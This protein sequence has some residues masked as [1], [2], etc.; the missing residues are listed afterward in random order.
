M[1]KIVVR[2]AREHNLKNIDVT[3]PRDKM[4]VVTG[5]SGSG[6]SS[7]VFDT[8]YAEGQRRYVE[9]LSSYARQFLGLMEKPDVDQIDGLSPAISIDQKSTSRNPRS[10]VGTVTEIY[11]YLRLLF[12]RIGVPHCP[13]CGKEITRQTS[14]QIVHQILEMPKGT[15]IMI[16]A[17][18]IK[19]K[20]GEHKYV[21]EELRKAGYTKVR[22][23]GK[24]YD[25]DEELN[26]HK[27]YKH[28][29]EAVADRLIVDPRNRRRFSESV[30]Q[31]LNLGEGVI[32]VLN[33]DS[34]KETT[35]S[36]NYAC[37]DCGINLPELSPRSFSFNSP[38]GA[39]PACTGLGT[40]L[41]VDPGLVVP[42]P[43]LTIAEGAI[44]PW[45]RTT[46]R[47]GWYTQILIAMGQK[48]DFSVNIPYKDLSQKARDLTMYGTG[49]EIIKV[50]LGNGRVYETT[51]EGVIANLGRRYKETDSEYVRKDIEKYMTVKTCQVCNGDRLKPEFASVTVS[52]QTIVDIVN[53]SIDKCLDLF[54]NLKLNERDAE[55][56][57][58][59]L[60]EIRERLQFM[61]NV[62]LNYL[63]LDRTARTLSGGEAQRIRLAT[64]IGSSLMGVL[65]IL[66]EP[67]IGLHQRDNSK[68]IA[69]LKKLRD[70]GNTVI[71][72][73]HD[74]ETMEEADWLLD[75]GPGAGEHGG[76]VI[77]QGTP[78]EVK[79]DK[80]SLTGQYLSGQKTVICPMKRRLGTGESLEI[81]GA[82]ENNLKN[83]DV[84]IP[85]GKMVV[86]TGV[87][88]SG[89]SSLINDTLAKKLANVYHRAQNTPG[90]HQDIL[91]LKN[92]DKVIDI[93]QS[94]I[95]RTPRSNPATYTGVFNNIRE[96]FAAVPE[97]KMRG[98]KSGRFS[99][100]VKGGRCEACHGE[101]IL[102]IEMHFLPDVYVTCE[103]CKGKRYNKEALE[104]YYKGKSIADVLSMTV[105]E[106]LDFFANIPAIRV[107]LQ[108]LMEV[109]L[110]YIR[111]GQPA[112]TLSGGEAQRVKLA[113]ELSRKATGKTLYILDEP[114][115]GLH[116]D[117]VNRLMS[118]LNAL[119]DLGNTVLIVEHN[120]DVIKCADHIIDLGPE[121]GD[122]G[123]EVVAQGTPEEVAKSEISYTGQ[124]LRK[125]AKILR[126][127]L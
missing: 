28:N 97:A 57:R 54:N 94:P 71:V 18:I 89:K 36:Q 12:A 111:L 29:I 96:L 65:Y 53:L 70:L 103:E 16:L 80:K 23:D 44:R 59:I 46:S 82:E 2:G 75:I 119:V 102:K 64:Q 113:T 90:K 120:L 83:I 9:S 73:E 5:L 21:F 22:V 25:T 85:L 33:V 91:G 51:Y 52:G 60:K 34:G 107:K 104:I 69:T 77:S 67:S 126:L 110:G 31:G 93:D 40:K 125:L 109:G 63:T 47:M 99:F 15:K 122:Q 100:N 81:I 58:Q 101:G 3:I 13:L 26:L 72:V 48:Y 45:A 35:F 42:N 68:L 24:I 61:L 79:A 115:T 14:E 8:I 30:E 76:K 108:T 95:G 92:L 117:D 88:G 7:L 86:V 19:G 124:Y 1:D 27:N 123:G 38:Y 78:A 20:K 106:A 6:K 84:K 118:V 127:K 11:D 105:E 4:V 116:F 10:T 37:E 121:G 112:T 55:I 39:C 62:G 41:E 66:D 114:T 49:D 17:P 32:Y 74:A 50:D 43:K 98:Y 87:S 56:A